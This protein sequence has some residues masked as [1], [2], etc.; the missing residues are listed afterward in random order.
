M[1][2]VLLIDPMMLNRKG[3]LKLQYYITAETGGATAQLLPKFTFGTLNIALFA[4]PLHV[5]V[6]LSVA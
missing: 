2:V 5:D 1:M 6:A 3:V 4:M